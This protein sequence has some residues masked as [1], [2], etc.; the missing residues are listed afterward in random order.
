MPS[1]KL[2]KRTKKTN[3]RRRLA[4]DLNRR[5]TFGPSAV[6]VLFLVAVSMGTIAGWMLGKEGIPLVPQAYLQ[7]PPV[8]DICGFA[9]KA[10]CQADPACAPP[11]PNGYPDSC[12]FHAQ[13]SEWCCPVGCTLEEICGNMLVE[14]NGTLPD[15]E[16]D[17]GGVCTSGGVP[18]CDTVENAKRCVA[19]NGTCTA[20][21]TGGADNC[22]ASCQSKIAQCGNGACE[23]V[24]GETC[25]SCASDCACGSGQACNASG[26]CVAGGGGGGGAACGNGTVNSGEQCDDGNTANLDGCSST[27][28]CEACGDGYKCA[29]E[30][31][32]DG[33]ISAGNPPGC[34]ALPLNNLDGCDSAC[35]KEGTCTDGLKTHEEKG[36]DCGGSPWPGVSSCIPCGCSSNADCNDGAYCT[37]DT[38]ESGIVGCTSSNGK[39]CKYTLFNADTGGSNTGPCN[40]DYKKIC[41]TIGNCSCNELTDRCELCKN[42]SGTPFPSDTLCKTTSNALCQ[43]HGNPTGCYEKIPPGAQWCCPGRE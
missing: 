37:V 6:A 18:N 16:C 5:L 28:V 3:A 20:Q 42:S 29:T 41:V 15:E 26:Q 19:T 35:K 2:P 10:A 11:P 32:D 13:T 22:D 4:G 12:Y 1:R 17:N 25:L 14:R 7:S 24:L 23:S 27:C 39:C 9:T 31:C 40:T 8:F 30:Q 38:C 34:D 43:D 36:I 21:D 33:C